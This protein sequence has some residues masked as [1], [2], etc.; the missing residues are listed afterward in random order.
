M[1]WNKKHFLERKKLKKGKQHWIWILFRISENSTNRLLTLLAVAS[2]AN[3][4]RKT[5]FCK[6]CCLRF[7]TDT[8]F[9][10][11]KLLLKDFI[12]ATWL[13]TSTMKSHFE[14][15]KHRNGTCKNCCKFYLRVTNWCNIDVYN[16][17]RAL[18]KSPSKIIVIKHFYF[19]LKIAT[20]KFQHPCFEILV[21]FSLFKLRGGFV[22]H[23]IWISDHVWKKFLLIK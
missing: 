9:G 20:T 3:F 2:F 13:K 17:M 10:N 1:L 5:V 23:S 8:F 18:T 6:N 22:F 21:S 7:A 12:F 4:Y 15:K 19:D 16:K 11:K 14:I